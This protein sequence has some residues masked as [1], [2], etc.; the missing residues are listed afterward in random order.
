M[1]V[2]AILDSHCSS[3][4]TILELEHIAN[5]DEGALSS[6]TVPVNVEMDQETE[7]P[8]TRTNDVLTTTCT[9][10]GTSNPGHATRFG[11]EQGVEN[12]E[13][14]KIDNDLIREAR[15]D[16]LKIVLFSKLEPVPTEPKESG[17]DSEG[18]NN[19]GGS[20]LNLKPYVSPSH[21]YNADLHAEGRL[22][23]P[24]LLHKKPR[25]TSS[26]LNVGDLQVGM[27]FSSKD[28]FVA[29]VKQY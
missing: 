19:V 11:N 2:E 1:E 12:K 5:V 20:N 28:A 23:F 8:T 14:S 13:G 22:E 4:S 26:L 6:I 21:M 9:S 16:G 27:E 17:S 25:L 29:V 10:D 7:S 24:K 3:G 15:P 18:P